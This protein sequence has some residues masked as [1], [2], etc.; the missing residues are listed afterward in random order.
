MLNELF[1]RILDAWNISKPFFN[2]TFIVIFLLTIFMYATYTD[3]LYYKIYDKFNI[4]LIICRVI[5]SIVPYYRLPLSFD[6]IF[7]GILGMVILIIPA[8][9]Y[10]QKMGG[11][12]KFIY[13]L[14]LYLGTTLTIGVLIFTCFYVL[15][16]S[17]IKKIITKQKVKKLKMPMAPFFNLSFV[18]LLLLSY[19]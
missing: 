6:H 15:L 13:V 12:I 1:I 19:I 7:A 3:T 9:M 18:T 11:D 14:G 16:F 8:V 2:N 10:M 5:F 17:L 4:F